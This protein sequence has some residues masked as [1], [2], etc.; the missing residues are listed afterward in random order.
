[1]LKTPNLIWQSSASYL[2][3]SLSSWTGDAFVLQ[4]VVF[5][6]ANVDKE[7]MMIQKQ[8]KQNYGKLTFFL[9]SV[10]VMSLL[11][12]E[13]IAFWIPSWTC[14][15]PQF[16]KSYQVMVFLNTSILSVIADHYLCIYFGSIASLTFSFNL[17]CN[18][19][20][21]ETWGMC[22]FYMLMSLGLEWRG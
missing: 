16:Q 11:Y 15:W 4:A 6:E 12:G 7:K 20:V 9:T 21:L 17:K 22:F 2:T 19:L 3:S 10:W 18:I 14:S 8:R 5:Y 1:M 13:M